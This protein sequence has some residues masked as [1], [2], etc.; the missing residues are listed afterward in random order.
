MIYPSLIRPENRFFGTF[1]S[2]SHTIY[3]TIEMVEGRCI[4]MEPTHDATGET[5]QGGS[6]SWMVEYT[7]Q[8]DEESHRHLSL[9]RADEVT[10]VQH[11]L[12]RELRKE[13]NTS[14]RVDV[15]V[16]RIE[17]VTTNTDALYFEGIYSP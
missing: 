13:Y 9:I 16:H 2:K 10:D 14:E 8:V 1:M 6:K 12:L 7:V 4:T 17:P 5:S 15:T 3:Q 11:Q